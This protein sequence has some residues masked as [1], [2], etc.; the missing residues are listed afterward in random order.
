MKSSQ[1]WFIIFKGSVI[2]FGIGLIG[3]GILYALSGKIPFFTT[4]FTGIILIWGIFAYITY[5]NFKRNGE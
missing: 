2:G 1:E 5:K 4:I 3:C